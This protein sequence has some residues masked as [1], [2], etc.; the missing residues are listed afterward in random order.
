MSNERNLDEKERILLRDFILR[1]QENNKLISTQEQLCEKMEK[2]IG[3]T[4]SGPTLSDWCRKLCVKPF[5]NKGHVGISNFE[6]Q[7]EIEK[8]RNRIEELEKVSIKN[9]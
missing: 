6:L 5:W 8:L 4:V 1:N 7:I 3:F 2:E 9:I